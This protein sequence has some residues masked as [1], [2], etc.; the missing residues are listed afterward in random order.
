MKEFIENEIVFSKEKK[1]WL[2]KNRK[3]IKYSDGYGNES[4]LKNIIA[5]INNPSSDLDELQ[6]FIID[7]QS[8]YHLSNKRI[9][10][11]KEFDFDQKATV[12]E[13]GCGCGAITRFLGKTFKHVIAI[14]GDTKRAEI[15]RLRTRDLENVLILSAPLQDI[16]FLRKF[17]IIFCIGF[18]E[19]ASLFLKTEDPFHH[20]LS[21][22]QNIL[23]DRGTLIIAIENK[24]GL[25]YFAGCPEDHSGIVFDGIEGYATFGENHAITLGKKEITDKLLNCKF[26]NISF[27]YPFPDYKFPQCIISEKI[28]LYPNLIN[29]AELI[30]DYVFKNFEGG[31]CSKF[32]EKFVWN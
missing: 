14:E 5:K 24:L 22:L 1:I 25:K 9:L 10:L 31:K 17:D 7:Y 30:G 15:A 21:F 19:Y 2:L 3:S 28:F 6:R 23:S 20:T 16:K 26:K 12:L 13:A 11:L 8:A 18:L 4:Y 27:Y 29:P 32:N